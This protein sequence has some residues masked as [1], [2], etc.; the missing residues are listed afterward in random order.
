[1]SVPS[2]AAHKKGGVMKLFLKAMPSFVIVL[3]SVV[4]VADRASAQSFPN[5]PET[6]VLDIQNIVNGILA[7]DDATIS[8]DLDFN[9]D[10]EVD[11]VDIQEIVN[12]ILQIPGEPF[13]DFESFDMQVNL[14]F[15]GLYPASNG[16]GGPY[17]FSL[18]EGVLP[19]GLTMT[20]VVWPGG[21]FGVTNAGLFPAGTLVLEITGTPTTAGSYLVGVELE[22][23]A[24]NK[25]RYRRV[26]VVEP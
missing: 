13:F 20:T 2:L 24:G 1:M 22:D 10:G 12:A 16:A 3:L 5:V 9:A 25:S 6:D 8:P 14:P 26:L 21:A 7:G 4:A 11:V 18:I 15:G 19:P 23:A 17:N